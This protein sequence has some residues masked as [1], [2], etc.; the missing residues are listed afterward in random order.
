MKAGHSELHICN[1][2]RTMTLD[3]EA[4]GAA[5]GLPPGSLTAHSDL[6]RS[7]LSRIEAALQGGAPLQIA[8][9]QEAPL[10]TEI[11][12]G[13]IEAGNQAAPVTFTDIRDAGGWSEQ[14]QAAMPK[15]AALLA[16]DRVPAEPAPSLTLTSDGVCLVYGNGQV[17]LDAARRLGERMSV[18]V[19]LKDADDAIPPRVVDQPIHT[20]RIAG[21]KG[22]LG[23]FEIVVD[24]YADMLPSSRDSL[25]FA[26][27][28]DGASAK[29]DVI[30][31]LSGG[32]ALFST[33]ERRPGYVRAD[34]T[35]PVAIAEALFKVAD[36]SGEFEKP[37]YVAFDSS[38]CAHSRS[39]KVGCTN[40][41]DVC[42][43]G[44]ISPKGDTVA[45]DA[46]ICG[47][48][49][50]CAAV[51][52][53]GAASYA[54]PRR[55]DMLA[56]LDAAVGTYLDAGGQRPV[57]AIL[58]EEDGREAVALMGRF[59]RGL[60][61]NVIPLYLPAVLSVGH[62]AM[63]GAI[64]LGAERC[65]LVPPQSR[66]DEMGSLLDQV[67]LANAFL[68][69]LG[70]GDARIAVIDEADPD[71]IEGAL[72]AL[73]PL[74]ATARSPGGFHTKASK[75]ETARILLSK[76]HG[77]APAPA[78]QIALPAGAPYGRIVV[79][80]DGCTL[81]LSCVGACPANALSDNPDRPELSFTEAACVQCGVCVATCPEQVIRLEPRYDFTTAALGPQVIKTEE[82]FTCVSCGKPFGTKAAV[83][84]VLARLEGHSM[85][86][87]SEQLKIIQMCDTCRI[88]TLANSGNDPFR[89]ADRPRVRTT[90]D[91]LEAEKRAA[92]K[93]GTLEPDDFLS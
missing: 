43:L 89:G 68:E 8:C 29:C 23:A 80:T 31:D 35:N 81:C 52:P 72:H 10:F 73:A 84:K 54:L 53:T 18:S 34:P 12:E 41:L 88:T 67:H 24:G 27:A 76:L 40:C 62:E 77:H 22:H 83:E 7:G 57:I 20:G 71:A 51:C 86:A 44:A 70:Y 33:G 93:K 5:L 19:L 13:L 50:N 46:A 63:A 37:R 16:A 21:A 79:D 26:M 39:G 49:G 3:A 17:A 60:P 55:G 78:A 75:R 85:F 48:C 65:V 58:D 32:D 56:K 91:Y 38:I 59:G 92:E 90:D 14:A 47:G 11:A 61:A 2:Q 6:C 4:I 42:P 28:R 64:A 87:N 69:G 36:L 30:L 45:I 66:R 1:C 25:Q 9:R 15:I 74:P 82:P